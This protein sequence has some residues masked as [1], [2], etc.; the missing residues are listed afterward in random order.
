MSQSLSRNDLAQGKSLA[1]RTIS[2]A[3][4]KRKNVQKSIIISEKLSQNLSGRKVQNNKEEGVF[5]FK[6]EE[7]WFSF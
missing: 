6:F 1:E 5:V 4:M 2:V 3:A 7:L